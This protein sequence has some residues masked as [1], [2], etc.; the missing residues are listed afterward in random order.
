[1]QALLSKFRSDREG[2]VAIMFGLMFI[3]TVL[4]LG[5]AVDSA[6]A[7]L[8]SAKIGAALDATALAAARAMRDTELTD[9]E[10]A[11]LAQKYF[12]ARID[13]RVPD[14]SS[15]DAVQ[16]SVNRANMT[17]TVAS[18]GRSLNHFGAILGVQEIAMTRQATAVYGVR[19]IE[20]GLMLDV[21]GSMGD[22]NKIGALKNA[23][24]D[25]I[26]V[27]LPPEK[28]GTG[29]VKIGMAPYSTAVNAGAYAALVRNTGGATNTCVT[30]RTGPHAFDD[31]APV[32]THKFNGDSSWCPNA[33]IVPITDDRDTLITALQALSPNG[34]TAGHLGTAWAWYLV[35]HKWAHIWPSNSQP[36][37]DNDS[38]VLKAVILMTDGMFNKRF[39]TENGTSSEQATRICE[40]M[41]QEKITVYAVAFDAPEEVLPLLRSC[42]VDAGRFFVANDE[43]ALRSAY[44][45]IAEEIASLRLTQ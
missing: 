13:A 35:S 6:R 20:L 33:R 12:S 9:S 31:Q 43:A 4:T 14:H 10:L 22:N 37:P 38:K 15:L 1:M 17:L 36:K 29:K 27:L 41:K 44:N 8:L 21:S 25:L 3:G 23:G 24:L 39:E 11:T 32:G 34:S 42:A 40:S 16:V 45:R 28:V 2:A 30:E 5:I 7:Y 19:D 18:V 26:N